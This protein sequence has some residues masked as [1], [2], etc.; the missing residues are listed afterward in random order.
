MPPSSS[1]IRA[2]VPR[3]VVVA[4]LLLTVVVLLVLVVGGVLDGTDGLVLAALLDLLGLGVLALVASALVW[5]RVGL[6]LAET[7]R[8]ERR[9]RQV[10]GRVVKQGRRLAKV[11]RVQG[12][13]VTGQGR[14]ERRQVDLHALVRHNHAHAARHREKVA[15]GTERQVAAVLD[16]DRLIPLA[17]HPALGGWAASPD[18]L[19]LLVQ[20]M[21]ADR[22]RVVLECGSGTS[23]LYLALAAKAHGIDCQIVA[24]DHDPAYTAQTRAL[25]HE[26]GVDDVAEVRHAPL[27]PSGIEGHTPLWYDADALEGVADVGML[28][29]DGPPGAGGPQARYPAVPMTRDLMAEHHVIVLD[30]VFRDDEREVAQRWSEEFADLDLRIDTDLQKHAAVLRRG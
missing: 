16:L 2:R 15:L 9:L 23:T 29:V 30:D 13:L 18:L 17:V 1:E 26:H 24:L 7:R 10:E 6:D 8:I 11:G 19:V 20:T 27:V 25:L 22:P 5:R 12:Q 28:V 14:V 4:A 21:L 3:A